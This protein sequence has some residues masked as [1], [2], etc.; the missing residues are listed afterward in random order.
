MKKVI[1]VNDFNKI[2]EKHF[3]VDS[4]YVEGV[5]LMGKSNV[6]FI[7]VGVGRMLDIHINL[8]E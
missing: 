4:C 7:E 6:E 3:N 5:T 8:S 2:L 1:T